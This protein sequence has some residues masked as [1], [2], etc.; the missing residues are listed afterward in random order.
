MPEVPSDI[1]SLT[2]VFQTSEEETDAQHRKI[3][4][5]YDDPKYGQFFVVEEVTEAAAAQG[6]L[7]GMGTAKPGCSPVAVTEPAGEVTTG[8]HCINEGFSL[9]KIRDD[10]TALLVEGPQVTSVTWI[11]A[12]DKDDVQSLSSFSDPGLMI[13]ILGPTASFSP[14]AAISVAN[15]L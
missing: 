4:W 1:G 10:V 5:V 14:A 3:A 6:E 11:Q 13:A 2:S 8:T 15:A 7:E 12:V 9:V